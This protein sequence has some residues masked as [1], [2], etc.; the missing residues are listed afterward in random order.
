M[1]RGR[2][3]GRPRRTWPQRLLITFNIAMVMATLGLAAALGYAN[4]KLEHVQHLDLGTGVL[5]PPAEDPGEP[6]NYLLVGTDSA[7][8]L[9][10]SDPAARADEGVL[11]DTIMVLRG[12]PRRD[13]GPVAVLSP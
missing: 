11:S 2:D 1:A 10:E 3:G 9:D 12:R 6:Q 5:D 13:P 8:R 7:A 4:D